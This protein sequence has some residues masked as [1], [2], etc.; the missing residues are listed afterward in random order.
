MFLALYV[1]YSLQQIL[2][3]H[4]QTAATVYK[5]IIFPWS[6][7]VELV[8]FIIHPKITILKSTAEVNSSSL[9]IYSRHEKGIS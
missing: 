9:S 8:S 5:N 3:T 4:I 1:N 6:L 7:I 2:C